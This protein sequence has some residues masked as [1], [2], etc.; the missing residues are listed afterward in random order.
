M[1]KLL[2]LLA[3]VA[4][5]TACSRDTLFT[6]WRFGGPR[7]GLEKEYLTPEQEVKF[8]NFFDVGNWA[9]VDW[10]LTRAEC[11]QRK[12]HLLQQ[13]TQSGRARFDWIAEDKVNYEGTLSGSMT[14]SC[15]PTGNA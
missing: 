6:L 4:L 13:V 1:R 7:T 2:L 9:Q 14:L 10:N 8:A 3:L 12:Q 11:E 5:V 15:A